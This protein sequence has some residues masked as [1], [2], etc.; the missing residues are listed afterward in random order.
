MPYEQTGWEYRIEDYTG[1]DFMPITV[2]AREAGIA[3][4]IY[5]HVSAAVTVAKQFT[6]DDADYYQILENDGI[7]MEIRS[8]FGEVKRM[9]AGGYR[10]FTYTAKEVEHGK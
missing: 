1:E 5:S 10:D 9:R 2:W 7:E 4:P 3:P 6:K 8:P